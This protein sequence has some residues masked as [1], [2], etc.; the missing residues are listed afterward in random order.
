M[1][2]RIRRRKLTRV[3]LDWLETFLAVVDSGG[4]TSASTQVHRSQS[5]VSAHIAALEKDLG[6][7][8]IDRS[9]RPATATE[10]G[11][12]LVAHARAV[13]AEIATSRSEIGVLRAMQAQSF[14]LLTTPGIGAVLLPGV[15]SG[16]LADHPEASVAVSERGWQDRNP[17]ELAGG[18][19]VAVVPTV[20]LPHVPGLREHLLWREPV[21]VVVPPDH[22]FALAAA[23][24]HPSRLARQTL[25]IGGPSWSAEPEITSL[26][27][28]RGVP[29][30][31][32][33]RLDDPATLVQ[34]VRR[35]L[36]VG[37]EKAVALA[38]TDTA[39]LVVLDID[40]PDMFSEV[41]IYWYDALLATE[42]G[43]S[44]HSGLRNAP[45]PAGAMPVGR[46]MGTVSLPA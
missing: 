25:L 32:R 42:L 6:V 9:R 38:N 5:R 16:M 10:A 20:A 2:V 19:A 7:R 24:V 17:E 36:G 44:L 3:E 11:H 41:A 18:F 8:L 15:L 29:T 37:V 12:L 27:A 34:M 26:L 13:L 21:Q 33:A 31:S 43:A 46:A 45:L 40:H 28:A 23:P 22:E 1:R 4:F 39:G 14:T 35:G 30:R